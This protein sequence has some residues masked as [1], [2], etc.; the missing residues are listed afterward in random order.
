[1]KLIEGEKL[2]DHLNEVILEFKPDWPRFEIHENLSRESNFTGLDP[3]GW[4]G[5]GLEMKKNDMF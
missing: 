3:V 2:N 1:M 4:F 5:A